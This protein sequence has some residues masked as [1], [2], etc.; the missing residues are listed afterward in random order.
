MRKALLPLGAVALA[1]GLVGAVPAQ[2]G[3]TSAANQNSWEVVTDGLDNPR[4]LA[5]GPRGG[6]FIAEAGRGSND[7][8]DCQGTGEDATCIGE[9]G[10]LSFIGHPRR[11][12]A[13]LRTIAD[14]FLSAAG[15]DGSFAVGSDGVGWTSAG[16]LFVPITFAP[17]DVLPDAPVSDQAGQLL[18]V[19]RA[20]GNYRSVADISRYE[21]KND[22]NNDGVESNPYAALGL[23]SGA[24]LVADAAGNSV[25]KVRRNGHISTFA[26]F[27]NLKSGEDYVP[28]SLARD[29]RGN[30][31]VGGLAGETPGKGKVTKLSPTGERLHRWGGFTTVTGV[32]VGEDK[33]LYVSELFANADFSDPDFDPSQAGQV[34]HVARNG[35]RHSEPV[36]LPAGIAVDDKGW[37]FV[38][39]W[40][41]APSDGAFGNPD[42]SGQVWRMKL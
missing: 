6:L 23:P 22:P 7:P 35:E 3:G 1:A 9:T 28:T 40:S 27:P 38:A 2:A 10:E 15:P 11:S 13:D 24:V 30:I 36:P 5:I 42:W 41:V 29:D 12:V 18:R 39:A 19:N 37:L 14:G 16:K 31:Y 34:T 33:S 4:Q 21:E 8:A 20:T 32:A 17:P 26:T 25:L